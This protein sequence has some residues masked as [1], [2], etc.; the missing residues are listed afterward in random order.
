MTDSRGK[1]KL[2]G[3][4]LISIVALPTCSRVV[5]DVRSKVEDTPA[6]PKVAARN[7]HGESGPIRGQ[8][9]ILFLTMNNFALDANEITKAFVKS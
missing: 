5:S 7:S 4:K 8:S 9:E 1:S 6:R 3:P 2:P